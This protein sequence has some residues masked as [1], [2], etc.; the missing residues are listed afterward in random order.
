MNRTAEQR[1]EISRGCRRSARS[2]AAR[3]AYFQALLALGSVFPRALADPIQAAAIVKAL[4]LLRDRVLPA[5]PAHAALRAVLDYRAART[6][7][8]FLRRN[9]AFIAAVREALAAQTPD[10]TPPANLGKGAGGNFDM[11]QRKYRHAENNPAPP[12]RATR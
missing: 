6:C 10:I 7:E 11:A 8:L 3:N 5:S 2:V 9:P 4:R 1:A 12:S